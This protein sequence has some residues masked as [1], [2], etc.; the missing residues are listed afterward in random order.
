MVR[1]ESREEKAWRPGPYFPLPLANY[2]RCSD[3]IDPQLE[4][5]AL[6]QPPF[7][8]AVYLDLRLAGILGQAHCLKLDHF[9]FSC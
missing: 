4:S 6:T 2:S 7:C 5:L 1:E 9:Q 3:I 8:F